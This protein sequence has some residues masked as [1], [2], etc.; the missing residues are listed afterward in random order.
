MSNVVTLPPAPPLSPYISYVFLIL[1]AMSVMC[2]Q[3]LFRAR[4]WQ[5]MLAQAMSMSVLTAISHYWMGNVNVFPLEPYFRFA[6]HPVSA[7]NRA[8]CPCP[9]YVA[10]NAYLSSTVFRIAFGS[11]VH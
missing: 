9:V 11:E 2:V 4:Q 8:V 3:I 5:T 1:I 10:V 7:S 6:A